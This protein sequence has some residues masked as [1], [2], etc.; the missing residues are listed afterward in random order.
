[1]LCANLDLK[2][3]EESENAK[4]YG[5]TDKNGHQNKNNKKKELSYIDLKKN[6][7]PDHICMTK[8]SINFSCLIS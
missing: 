8:N 4:L 5:E 2:I 1:M 6:Q 3:A 7:S